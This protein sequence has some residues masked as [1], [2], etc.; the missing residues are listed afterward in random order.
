MLGFFPPAVSPSPIRPPAQWDNWKTLVRAFFAE[1]AADPRFGAEAIADWWFEVWN[2]PNEGRFWQGAPA[3]Y[4]ALYRA[5]SEAVRESGVEIRL[6]GPAIAYKPEADPEAG[7]PWMGSFLR[8]IA[9]NPDLRCDF[10]SLHRKGTVGDDPPDPARLHDAAAQTASQALAIDARRF[11]GITI[12]NNEADEKV[13]FEVPYAPRN[14]AHGASWLA[15]VTVIHDR[16]GERYG[17]ADLR[18]AAA[19]DNAN[20]QLVRS[21]FDGRRSIMTRA[22]PSHS[23]TDL[24]KVPAYGFYE[25]L[26]LLGD[27]HGHIDSGAEHL[28]PQRDSTISSRW[29]LPSRRA[30]SL[31]PDPK[32]Q[33]PHPGR[34][35]T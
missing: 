23:E 29:R 13:G 4:L 35:T 30:P 22:G 1:L 24:I 20:L 28:F 34:T 26:R 10:I 9:A 5:T 19:A 16:L 17:T 6:G 27:R 2:E 7:P 25:L 32:P 8:F 3:D 31:L 21:S 12:W 33:R 14:D 15:A 18:F 11:A